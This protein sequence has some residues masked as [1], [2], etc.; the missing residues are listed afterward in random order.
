[1][2]RRY[3]ERDRWA[4][5][6]LY[7]RAH[8]YFVPVRPG[9]DWKCG[10]FGSFIT[11][12]FRNMFGGSGMMDHMD[13][14]IRQNRELLDR[15]KESFKRRQSIHVAKNIELKFKQATPEELAVIR[16][17]LLLQAIKRDKKIRIALI[18]M[19]VILMVLFAVLWKLGFFNS[20][21]TTS[22]E[23]ITDENKTLIYQA[24]VKLDS[25]FIEHNYQIFRDLFHGKPSRM[26]A[27]LHSQLHQF[28]MQYGAVPSIVDL[29]H[30]DW[31]SESLVHLTAPDSTI[32][33]RYRFQIYNRK[34]LITD[35][36]IGDW[37]KE[38]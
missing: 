29:K 24:A 19:P 5:S 25:S 7:S 11:K 34:A 38:K 14:S 32:V 10:E 22:F 20:S 33:I 26:Q 15:A 35:F 30:L 12:S 16:E 27:L 2:R 28:T 17:Y 3:L 21:T 9:L 13:K 23:K 18:S 6:G 8:L 4:V 31:Q 37:P 36:V 1:M